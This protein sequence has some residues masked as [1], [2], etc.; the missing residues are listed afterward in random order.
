VIHHRNLVAEAFE[1]A[2]E[3]RHT[4]TRIAVFVVLASAAYLFLRLFF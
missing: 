3:S 4:G 1:R 2:V